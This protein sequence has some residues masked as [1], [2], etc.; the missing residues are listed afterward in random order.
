MLKRIKLVCENV[1]FVQIQTA[2]HVF[3]FR[4][5]LGNLLLAIMTVPKIFYIRK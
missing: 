1:S 5:C 2:V 3:V 4:R